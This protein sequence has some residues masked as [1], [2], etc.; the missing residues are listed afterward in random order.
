MSTG[1]L[2]VRML[3]ALTLAFLTVSTALFW[4]PL[5][6]RLGGWATGSY[7]DYGYGDYS[8]SYSYYADTYTPA[9]DALKEAAAEAE[10]A[11]LE[12]IAGEL[13]KK[14][15]TDLNKVKA[16]PDICATYLVDCRGLADP[17]VRPFIDAVLADRQMAI[18]RDALTASQGANVIALGS[19]VVAIF[20]LA[21]SILGMMRK[22]A[23]T[24]RHRATS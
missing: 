18:S 1:R 23:A 4:L 16:F 24:D 21:L 11:T 17:A 19:C 20:A 22:N 7:S 8:Y 9:A 14:T 6:P 12:D 13:E 2:L 5:W 10:R 3:G 15:N